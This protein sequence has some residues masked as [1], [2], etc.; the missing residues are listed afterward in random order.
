MS[1]LRV[2]LGALR[3]DF[4]VA[5]ADLGAPRADSA[6]PRADLGA[7]RA[8]SAAPNAQPAAPKADWGAPRRARSLRPWAAQLRRCAG[9][10][11]GRCVLGTSRKMAAPPDMEL[12][13]SLSLELLPTDPL[14]LILSF[15]DYRDLVRYGRPGGMARAR[16][17]ERSPGCAGKGFACLRRRR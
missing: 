1:V 14:L 10:C 11:D 12:S 5:R 9:R 4:R 2:D 13:P 7:P 16:R 17:A 3:A 15:L 8:D 6:A